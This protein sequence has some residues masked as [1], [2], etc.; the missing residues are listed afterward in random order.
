M[1][2]LNGEVKPFGEF[3]KEYPI[4]DF[5]ENHLATKKGKYPHDN[6]VRNNMSAVGYEKMVTALKEYVKET[7]VETD[8]SVDSNK[9]AT[10]EKSSSK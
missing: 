2:E 7:K 8:K 9:S 5:G 6:F 3:I 4:W 10:D 1:F